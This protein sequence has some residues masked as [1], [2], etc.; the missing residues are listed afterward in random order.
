[1][2]LIKRLT[3]P[4]KS[5]QDYLQV[6][7]GSVVGRGIA[8]LNSILIA[9]ILGPEQFGVFV[10]FFAVMMLTWLMLSAFDT[11][12]IRHAKDVT[13]NQEKRSYLSSNLII[14]TGFGIFFLACVAVVDKSVAVSLFGKD[15]AHQLLLTGIGAGLFLNYVMTLATIYR[16]REQFHLFT[17]VMNVH[18]IF[19]FVIIL[20]LWFSMKHFTLK[21]IIST[22]I[23][24]AVTAGTLSLI[25]IWKIEQP[26]LPRLAI[27]KSFVSWGKWIFLLSIVVAVFDRVDFFFLTKYLKP[28]DIGVYAAG[29][30]LVLI[31]SLTTGALSNVFMPKAVVALK[32]RDA[33]RNYIRES[34]TPV[35]MVIVIIS[36]IILSAPLLIKGLYGQQY[37]AAVP[38]AR[39]ISLGWL[40]A[41]IY[42]PFSFIFYTIDEPHTR[43]YLELGK[44]IL[45]IVFLVLLVPLYGTKG[46]ALSVTMALL[47]NALMS[48]LILW[49][50][51]NRPGLFIGEAVRVGRILS[52]RSTRD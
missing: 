14:K 1:M 9:R 20:I 2:D 6:I 47:T 48:G 12:Y 19:V 5:L 21:A 43:F 10:F 52:P 26:S 51:L 30:Q 15:Y 42:L 29:A 34:I 39:I 17:V 38:I 35:I 40:G 13:S 41:S 25:L 36:L 31:I 37:E 28:V 18:T 3:K 32:S 33:L 7:F 4:D 27:F 49:R 22:Y 8:F 44:L 50:K 46:A 24:S 11:A 16:E 23:I 45:G